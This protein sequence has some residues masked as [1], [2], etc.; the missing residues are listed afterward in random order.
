VRIFLHPYAICAS[1]VAQS[2]RAYQSRACGR[3]FLSSGA[4]FCMFGESRASSPLF[5][6]ARQ[7]GLMP[8]SLPPRP[9]PS[10]IESL[11]RTIAVALLDCLLRRT[12]GPLSTV[13]TNEV[14]DAPRLIIEGSAGVGP[15]CA[16]LHERRNL[17]G[18]R[19]NTT[20]GQ[21]RSGVGTPGRGGRPRNLFPSCPNQ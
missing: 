7:V 17:R 15:S 8:T 1:S 3:A 13:K 14:E 18:S 2:A 20:T 11:D 9:H 21:D 6:S 5:C 12:R 4:A 10:V 19:S 16:L